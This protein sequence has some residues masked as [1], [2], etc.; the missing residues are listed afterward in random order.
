MEPSYRYCGTGMV[1]EE[2][3]YCASCKTPHH[4][5]CFLQKGC[6]VYACGETHYYVGKEENTVYDAKGKISGINALVAKEQNLPATTD[7][8]DTFLTEME[9]VRTQYSN[10]LPIDA[11]IELV[12]SRHHIANRNIGSLCLEASIKIFN[13]QQQYRMKRANSENKHLPLVV[14]TMVAPMVGGFILTLVSFIPEK[15]I[16]LYWLG[17]ASMPMGISLGLFLDSYMRKSDEYK[18][19][20]MHVREEEQEKIDEVKQ[21]YRLLIGNL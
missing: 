17:M 11:L 1:L 15:N 7:T 10:S 20:V 13:V 6:T 2:A 21:E 19:R 9:N 18:E 8:L 5:D 3:S 12:C 16:L 4:F 14:S